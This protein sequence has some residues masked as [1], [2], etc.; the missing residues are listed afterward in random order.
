MYG[1]ALYF[2]KQDDP[3]ARNVACGVSIPIAPDTFV[4]PFTVTLWVKLDENSTYRQFKDLL[5]LGGERGP[6]FRLTYFYI[7]L[8]ARTGDGKNVLTVST[9]SS[10]VLLPL[11]RW[12]QVA[13]VYDGEYCTLY[14]D[15]VQKAR[16]SLANLFN[17]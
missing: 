13:V 12:F 17:F 2:P 3:N 10:T 14:I 15:A 5:S 11:K 9:N 1:K 7:S 16:E 4:N 6:G 8:V